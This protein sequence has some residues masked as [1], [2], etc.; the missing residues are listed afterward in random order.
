M[1]SLTFM[2]ATLPRLTHEREYAYSS[3]MAS[4]ISKEQLIALIDA[5]IR[6]HGS[7]RAAARE[8]G[9]SQ[10]YLSDVRHGRRDAGQKLLDALYLE[11]EPRYRK[12]GA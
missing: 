5:L 9:V 3:G 11:K 12:L 8:L 1:L 7:G 2:R 6:E 4:T 10:S